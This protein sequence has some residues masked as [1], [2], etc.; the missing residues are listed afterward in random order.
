MIVKYFLYLSF[1][2]QKHESIESTYFRE[3][4]RNKM[5]FFTQNLSKSNHMIS[6]YEKPNKYF[7]SILMTENECRFSSFF[8]RSTKNAKRLHSTESM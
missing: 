6:E 1:L 2:F 5:Q 7:V 3:T 4:Y 8:A